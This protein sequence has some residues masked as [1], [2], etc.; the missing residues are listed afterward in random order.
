MSGSSDTDPSGDS[1]AGKDRDK[2]LRPGTVLAWSVLRMVGDCRDAWARHAADCP[3][4]ELEP[5]P[6]RIRA[7][8]QADLDAAHIQLL[9]FRFRH[10]FQDD[11]PESGHACGPLPSVASIRFV[12][13]RARSSGSFRSIAL[14][15]GCRSEARPCRSFCKSR[16]REDR[17]RERSPLRSRLRRGGP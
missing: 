9:A 10:G 17:A 12:S 2:A 14:Y 6:L 13:R 3:A 8:T 1:V 7:Q 4:H 15:A 5:R 16:S 11:E